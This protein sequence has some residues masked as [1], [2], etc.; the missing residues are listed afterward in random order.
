MYTGTQHFRSKIGTGNVRPFI[1]ILYKAVQ[2]FDA[3]NI[4]QFNHNTKNTIDYG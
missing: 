3:P 4:H 2:L 1:Y